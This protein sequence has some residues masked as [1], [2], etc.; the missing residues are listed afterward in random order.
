MIALATLTVASCLAVN[1]NSDRIL[2]G[3]LAAAISGLSVAA[4]EIPVAMAPAPGVQRI[5]RVTELRRMAEHY[6]W[7]WQPDADIC[8]TRPVSPLDPARLLSAMRHVLPEAEI[9]LLDYGRQPVPVGEMEFQSSGLHPGTSGALWMGCIRYAGTHR[10]PVWARVKVLVPVTSVTAAVDLEPGR[11]IGADEIRV[12]TRREF[13]A[14][15]PMLSSSNEVVGKWP[16]SAIHAGAAI[17]PAMIE[18]PKLVARGDTVTVDVFEGAAHL[19][20][21]G[22]AEESGALGQTIPVLNPD[23]HKQFS[24]RVAGKGRVAV[25]S[26]AAKVNP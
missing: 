11:A 12:E 17:R 21:D 13:P 2:A 5:F 1:P 15:E 6:G 10:F 22:V 7:N 18:N 16:R 20:L 8:V 3:D 9:A 26:P 4:P 24:A 23:S 25:G 14:A 19:E